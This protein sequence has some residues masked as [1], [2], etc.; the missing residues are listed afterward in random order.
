MDE[1]LTPND[2]ASRSQAI[3]AVIDQFLSQQMAGNGPSVEQVLASNEQLLP[4]LKQELQRANLIVMAR[5]MKE[6]APT[7]ESREAEE[8]DAEG[9]SQLASEDGSLMGWQP[10]SQSGRFASLFNYLQHLSD[11]TSRLLDK[12]TA[13]HQGASATDRSPNDLP[14]DAPRSLG[15]YELK[16]MLGQGGFGRVYHAY[17]T[18]LKRDVAI[19]VPHPTR[20]ERLR[21][22]EAYLN[23]ARHVAQLDHPHIVPV[24]DAGQTEEGW[25]YVVSKY[26]SGGDLA[27]M[28][29][30]EPLQIDDAVELMVTIA[31]ALDHAHQ[32]GIIHRDIKPANILV[33]DDGC[34]FLA[35]FGLA[36]RDTDP[37]TLL[38]QGGTP[39]Y[40]SPEQACGEGHRV[41]P[42]SDIFSLGVV[43]YELL[44]G[45]RPFTSSSLTRL[46]QMIESEE[47][48]P[49][50]TLRAEIDATLERIAVRA[51]SKRISDRQATALELAS[52]LQDYLEKKRTGVA[53]ALT[54]CDGQLATLPL[55]TNLRPLQ[56]IDTR[57]FLE[58]LPGPRDASGVPQSVQFWKDRIDVRGPR[59][60]FRVGLLYGPSGSGKS[61]FLH[62]GLLP[63]LSKNVI[64][65][66]LETHPSGTEQRL[67]RA[68]RRA[69]PELVETLTLPE[70]VTVIRRGDGLEKGDRLLVVLD[71]F[72]QWLHGNLESAETELVRTLRQCDG[73]R[74]QTLLVVRDDF[75]LATSRLMQAIEVPIIEGNNSRLLEPF[76]EKHLRR[77]A[78]AWYRTVNGTADAVAQ[79]PSLDEA[80][81]I[82]PAAADEFADAVVGLLATETTLSRAPLHLAMLVML[83]GRERWTAD[84]VRSFRSVA[85][86]QQLY[87]RRWFDGSDAPLE[88]RN[89]A[90]AIRQVLHVLAGDA[91]TLKAEPVS[92]DRLQRASGYEQQ[93][94]AF[95]ELL[96]ILDQRMRLVQAVDETAT[97][98]NVA[99][100]ELANSE[101]SK[102]T[103][104]IRYQLGHD[105]LVPIV[106]QWLAD[107]RRATRTGRAQEL[108][109]E[110]AG[111]WS[112][113]PASTQLP[114]ILETL[115]IRLGT[116]RREWSVDQRRMMR[117]ASV[118]HVARTGV[119]IVALTVLASGWLVYDRQIRAQFLVKRLVQ[120][121]AAAVPGILN[122][123]QAM[124][125]WVLSPLRDAVRLPDHAESA[126]L[127]LRLALAAEDERTLDEAIER[128][129]RLDSE[130]FAQ[131]YQTLP[132]RADVADKL[133][134]RLKSDRGSPASRLRALAIV[135]AQSEK[136]ASDMDMAAYAIWVPDALISELKREPLLAK[137]WIDRM[138]PL[139][140][141][142]IK[143]LETRLLPPAEGAVG[144]SDDE[145]LIAARLLVEYEPNDCDRLWNWLRQADSQHVSYFLDA[146]RRSTREGTG[147]AWLQSRAD[148][149]PWHGMAS[150]ESLADGQRRAFYH[151]ESSGAMAVALLGRPERLRRWLSRS[152]QPAA[153]EQVW[154]K[155]NDWNVPIEWWADE[156]RGATNP[157]LQR[158]I[159]VA[160][161]EYDG[162]KISAV[163]RESLVAPLR[164]LVAHPD[165]GTHSASLWLMTR[166]NVAPANEPGD[167]SN[168]LQ[169]SEANG[170]QVTQKWH[171]NGIG[172]TMVQLTGPTDFVMGSPDH[173][174]GRTQYETLHRREV[175]RSFAISAYEVTLSQWDQFL[176]AGNTSLRGDVDGDG[177][178]LVA[179]DRVVEAID[180]DDTKLSQ[181]PSHGDRPVILIN[182]YQAVAFCNWLSEREGIP[183]DQWC[184]EPNGDGRYAEGMKPA[185]DFLERTGYRLPTE[186][187]WEM[188]CRAGSR[189]ARWSG[190]DEQALA[191]IAWYRNNS[192]GL[193]HPVG[194]RPPNAWGLFD[195]LGNAF[196]WCH[197]SMYRYP[198]AG[199]THVDD[200]DLSVVR[201]NDWRILR[202]GSFQSQPEMVRC[203][204]RYTANPTEKSAYGLRPARTIN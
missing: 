48:T 64:V 161:G 58:M 147:A 193:E 19:K 84:R 157:A 105:G 39:A 116:R 90:Q 50:R 167:R 103:H 72:E 37:A 137:F 118:H 111:S 183:R 49:L 44:G 33:D 153:Q 75:W 17:D 18:R 47:P 166:W 159:L 8:G 79:R 148:E 59:E 190:D 114:G 63:L 163:V 76:D 106:R 191:R 115:Q 100:A 71:Q 104:D 52:E 91:T 102:E 20:T 178:A 99:A 172:M 173:E 13:G 29:K 3:R 170:S 168:D 31:R 94:T 186:G 184:Y 201:D 192:A 43:L 70:M 112:R 179:S 101:R 54:E 42:R 55:P 195:T 136:H 82:E 135:L 143:P 80:A 22:A 134:V 197:E 176:A 12:G 151:E 120:A 46:R 38:G 89:H 165:A 142:L 96:E 98:E 196:E 78:T 152:D 150:T 53:S 68:L 108:L 10:S 87:L 93:A 181:T 83:L 30:D 1:P 36:Q 25:C 158:A 119:W 194:S 124:R 149:D 60:P 175:P 169:S 40:M 26:I 21:D 130:R 73:D 126:Q 67:R 57:A 34:A 41:G 188:A 35:D 110:R 182:W 69:F 156:L 127:H 56:T 2:A 162:S 203:A 97:T 131:L 62:S 154:A 28:I 145:R 160:L 27:S 109:E 88:F 7:L 141:R 129:V 133:I 85:V 204:Y 14:A 185:A 6:A 113:Q 4:E 23:E 121:E 177:R 180:A 187:E 164:Q 92:R 9:G 128:L 199:A 125:R 15:R 155:I 117:A 24:Y 66:Y 171:T 32:R 139:A 122:E 200:A 189:A 144:T 51:L 198:R 132:R 74:V 16:R 123:V 11:T 95:D 5:R 65:V 86:M 77:L 174:V 61:T 107:E 146:L 138:R 202:G 81:G 45:K 140:P